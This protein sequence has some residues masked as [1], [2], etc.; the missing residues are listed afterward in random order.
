MESD[1][2]SRIGSQIRAYRQSMNLSLQELADAANVSKSLLSKLE[3]GRMICSL[4]MLISI[5][6]IFNISLTQFF[7]GVDSAQN[8]RIMIIKESDYTRTEKETNQTG[9]TYLSVL[10][11][12]VGNLPV[13]IVILTIKSGIKRKPVQTDAYEYK[14]ILQG[15][16]NYHFD[17]K[18][19][20]LEQGDSLFFDG[21][22]PHYPY[23]AG[24]EDVKMLVVYFY[25]SSDSDA[26]SFV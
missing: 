2:I 16:I 26:I 15:Q 18:I 3:N 4:P 19:V 7:S 6:K 9:F 20:V 13:E 23:N 24:K 17:N 10:N 1:F 22:I 11:K 21:R 5:I 8:N 25:L 12:L 14:Y